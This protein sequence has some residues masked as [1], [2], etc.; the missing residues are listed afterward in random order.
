MEEN[1]R[2]E[3]NFGAHVHW[4]GP[5]QTHDSVFGAQYAFDIDEG[6]N[7][8]LPSDL[9]AS[10]YYITN[11]YNYFLGNAASGGFAGFAFVNLPT[12]VK[13]NEEYGGYGQFS[14]MSRP[15]LQFKGNTAHSTAYWN[16]QA[17]A[18]YVGGT[19][20]H[21]TKGGT[22]RYNSGR[23]LER[24]TCRVDPS[25]TWNWCQRPDYMWMVF[26]DS[27][28]FLANRGMQHWGSRA[29]VIRAEFH[30][31]GMSSNV[32]G[33]VALHDLLIN[34]R[35]LEHVPASLCPSK[36]CQ[37]RDR[38]FFEYFFGFQW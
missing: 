20:W 7:L 12:P 25:T 3:Y 29:E 31:V 28:V 6:P 13:L 37:R 30:D 36:T 5:T 17:G 10:V 23:R 19:L 9:G 18:I 24:Y 21:V 14:P 11:S 38:V 35:S 34:C 22:L 1:N 16:E 2:F 32:F 27:K 4:L 8:I 26:E 15:L 33:K